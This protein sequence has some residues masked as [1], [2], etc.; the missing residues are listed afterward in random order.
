[1]ER[2]TEIILRLFAAIITLLHKQDKNYSILHTLENSTVKIGQ[3]YRN[4]TKCYQQTISDPEVNHNFMTKG[5]L[6]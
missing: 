6:Q 4:I 1:M 5:K 2:G 3:V